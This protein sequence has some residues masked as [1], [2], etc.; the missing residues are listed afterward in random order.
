MTL[1]LR[2]FALIAVS[3]AALALAGC[4]T[5]A[6]VVSDEAYIARLTGAAEVPGPGDADGSISARRPR[7]T[8]IAA[9]PA[10][11]GRRW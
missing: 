10:P 7:R 3:A 1:P 4:E 6:D 8:S 11:P 2:P 9:A 5:V